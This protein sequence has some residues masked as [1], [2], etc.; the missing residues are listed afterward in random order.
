MAAWIVAAALL[1]RTTVP[2]N[3][4]LPRLDAR[5][6]FS[7][8]ELARTARYERFLRI[9]VL[10]ST[11]TAIA[12]LL[13]FVARAPRLARNTGLGPIGAGLIVGMLLLIG[14]WAADLPFAIALRWWDQRHGLATGP[15]DEWL[16]DPWA[17]LTGAVALVMLQI[18]V[19]M[20]FARRYP[21]NWWLPV[22]P[23]FLG[24]ATLFV[25]VAPYLLAFGINAP[26]NP[27]LKND[28]QRL[29]Q[30]EHVEGTPVDVEKV[31]NITTEANAFATG[32]GPTTRVVLWDTLLD[33]RF[34]RGE[35]RFVVAHELGHIAHKHIWKGLGWAIL[36][37]FPITFLLA[38]ATARRGGL[39][40]PGVLPYGFLVLLIVNI[41]LTPLGNVVSRHEES[42]A[43]WSA[44]RATRD[45][46]SGRGLFQEF[47]KTSLQQPN[48]PTWAY[49]YFDT[50]PTIMQRIAMTEDWK[51]R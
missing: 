51:K 41:A 8:S 16:L 18:A 23:I 38:R 5:D 19:L 22:T 50:H 6:Y 37:A 34:S 43:D 21:R 31:S 45:P 1:W 29:E 24:L 10:L 2:G 4:D 33:G 28:I 48:P 42:E 7:T 9:D 49:V 30:A 12:V 11:L 17:Q 3:L 40:D 25:F 46:A 36:F 27:Q 32:L 47:S 35:V 26:K 15:W 39:G 20:A 14:L 44:L 13:F